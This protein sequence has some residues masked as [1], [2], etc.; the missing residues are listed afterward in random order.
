L[1][2]LEQCRQSFLKE[3]VLKNLCCARSLISLPRRSFIQHLNHTVSLG[4]ARSTFSIWRFSSQGAT[5]GQCYGSV[6]IDAED[7]TIY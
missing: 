3:A 1:I 2:T 5:E 7:K 4:R 6:R